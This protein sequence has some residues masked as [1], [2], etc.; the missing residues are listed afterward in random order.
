M[1]GK[2]AEIIKFFKYNTHP[3]RIEAKARKV[4]LF[5]ANLALECFRDGRFREL[6]NFKNLDE[7]EQNRIFNELT[8]TNLVMA[9]LLVDQIIRETDNNDKKQY[10]KTVREALPDYYVNF[11]RRIGI[12]EAYVTLWDKLIAMRYDEYANDMGE[13]RREFLSSQD[14]KLAELALDNDVVLFQTLALGLYRHIMRGKIKKGD[15]L[16]VRHIQPYLL[17]VYNGVLQR[18]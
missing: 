13:F 15:P 9:M 5:G 12:A 3:A 1:L 7:E 4:A 17:G 11:L 8:V 2:I 10:L 18:I 16:Y 14:K 6:A